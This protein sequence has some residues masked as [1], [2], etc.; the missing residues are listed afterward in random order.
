MRVAYA[1]PPYV[2]QAKKFYAKHPDYAGEVDQAALV[3]RLV[4]EFPDGWALSCHVNSLR[5]I[6]PLCH[7][8][9]RVAAWVKPFAFFKPGV[10][11]KYAWEPV[12]F[13]TTR[14]DRQRRKFGID[15]PR[16]W[17]SCNVHGATEAERNRSTLRGRKPEAFCWWLFNLLGLAPGDELVDLFPGTGAVTA[18][19]ERYQREPC[20]SGPLFAKE[21]GA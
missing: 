11:P 14:S 9:V 17:V 10:A 8:S 3:A 6:L 1:D 15:S 20:I 12:L 16:D 13:V 2:G 21:T 18:A 4:R 5:T 7:E 19:W